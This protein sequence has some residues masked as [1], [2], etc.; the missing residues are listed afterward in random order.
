M[1]HSGCYPKATAMMENWPV[2]YHPNQRHVAVQA[3]YIAANYDTIWG[4]TKLVSRYDFPVI[5]RGL[6]WSKS[7]VRNVPIIAVSYMRLYDYD[8]NSHFSEFRK[9]GDGRLFRLVAEKGD[10]KIFD[11]F[12]YLNSWKNK[13]FL[14]EP[15]Q[16]VQLFSWFAYCLHFGNKRPLL[17]KFIN[18]RYHVKLHEKDFKSKEEMFSY[19]VVREN[20]RLLTSPSPGKSAPQ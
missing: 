7:N 18:R 9:L 19:I 15:Q 16:T 14:I 8:F 5:P 10:V 20:A 13:T 2:V 12:L 11:N 6:P 4:Y 1:L 3:A 17:L